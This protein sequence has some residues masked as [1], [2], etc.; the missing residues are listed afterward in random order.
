MGNYASTSSGYLVQIRPHHSA[1]ADARIESLT[2]LPFLAGRPYTGSMR[3]VLA[4]ADTAAVG[5][6]TDA[7]QALIAAA[8]AS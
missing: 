1:V 6:S 3:L 8:R 7:P 4:A 5:H 2:S